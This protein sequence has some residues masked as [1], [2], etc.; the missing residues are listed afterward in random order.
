MI[1][2]EALIKKVHIRWQ[3]YVLLGRWTRAD[4]VKRLLGRLEQASMP[5]RKVS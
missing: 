5:L 3:Y 4:R 2:I 1:V